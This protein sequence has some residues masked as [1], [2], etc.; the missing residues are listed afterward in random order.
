MLKTVKSQNENSVTDIYVNEDY[1]PYSI[2][3]D[4]EIKSWCT[5]NSINFHSS[6]DVTLVPPGSVVNPQGKPFDVYTHFYQACCERTIDPLLE[7]QNYESFESIQS[8]FRIDFDK[9]AT[10]Y[11][12]NPHINVNGGRSLAL[13]IL[14]SYDMN[15]YSRRDELILQGTTSLSAHIKFGCISIREAYHH[16]NSAELGKDIVKQLFWR[17]YFIMLGHFHPHMLGAALNPKYNALQWS[18][19]NEHFEAW[20]NGQTGF[21]VIDA[22]MVQLATTG[23]LNNRARTFVADFL[24]K[25]LLIDWRKGEKYFATILVDY[26]PLGKFII[27]N[28]QLHL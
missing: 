21:P 17:D 5:N 12:H 24:V 10:F 9:A 2:K 14:K 4:E 11:K 13:E 28:M 26:D 3:R 6:H 15:L 18:D 8:K 27:L 25:L 23:Y 7:N 19:N 1:T 16:F 22:A 20:K